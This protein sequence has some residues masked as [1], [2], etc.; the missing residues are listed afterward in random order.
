MHA[1]VRRRIERVTQARLVLERS[2]RLALDDAEMQVRADR[3]RAATIVALVA[4]QVTLFDPDLG[5][6]GR[7]AVEDVRSIAITRGHVRVI[8]P[9]RAARVQR[10]IVPDDHARYPTLKPRQSARVRCDHRYGSRRAIPEDVQPGVAPEDVVRAGWI[11]PQQADQ[12]FGR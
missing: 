5:C 4:E 6:A 12:P 2:I 1:Q 3:D 7:E 8:R 9:D 10:V 11:A